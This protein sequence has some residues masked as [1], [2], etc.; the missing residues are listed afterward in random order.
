MASHIRIP[1]VLKKETGSIGRRPESG[2]P[3]RITAEIRVTLSVTGG[4]DP[5]MLLEYFNKVVQC[6]RSPQYPRT[7]E[8]WKRYAC[9]YMEEQEEV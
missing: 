1:K 7:S 2:W 4:P 5:C 8:E 6:Q 3:S 9:M